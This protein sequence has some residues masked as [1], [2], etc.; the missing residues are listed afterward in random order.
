MHIVKT[1]WVIQNNEAVLN[2]LIDLNKRRRGNR[3]STFNF[4]TLYAKIPHSK[5]LDV[6]SE[7][8]FVSEGLKI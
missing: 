1:F 2:S 8:T 7:I 5:L 4:S 6:L 3:I